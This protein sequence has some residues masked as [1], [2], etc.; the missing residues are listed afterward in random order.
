M[1]TSEKKYNDFAGLRKF[2]SPAKYI[3]TYFVII[4]CIIGFITCE[5]NHPSNPYDNL[6]PE[7]TI[8]IQSTDTLN[9][10]Q[11]VQ[12]ISWDGRDPDGFVVGFY[13][14]WQE[15][16]D[17]NDWIFTNERSLTFPLVITGSDTLYTFQIKAMDNDSLIDLSPATQ[18]FPIKNSPPE[19]RWTL[20]S[21]IPDTTYT[22]ASFLWEATDL[23]G[24]NTISNF[25][26]V[27]VVLVKFKILGNI[28]NIIIN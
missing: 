28:I 10:T 14:T 18:L 20:V 19:I 23:D 5:K 27:R 11:S 8:F 1:S 6:A 4:F 13:Y 12:K 2:H 7:T 15:T 26:W 24:D 25:E 21:R 17:E 22:V 16:P 3:F 9:Y